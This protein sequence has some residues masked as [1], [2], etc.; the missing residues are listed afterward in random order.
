MGV[1][2]TRSME[3]IAAALG[4]LDEAAPL[5]ERADDIPNGGVLCALPALLHLGLLRHSEDRFDWPKGFYSMAS[6]FV[7]LAFLALGRIR[8]LEQLRYQAPGEWGKLLGLD[9]VPEVKTMREKIGML[10]DDA[11]RTAQW[12]SKLAA[13]WMAADVGAAGVLLIDGHTRVYHGKLAK[14]PRRYIA[15]EK[16]CLR[17]TSDYWVNAMNGDP[18]FCVTKAVDPG[19]I[20]TLEEDIVPRLLNEVP[21]Q[22]SAQQLEADA[23]LHRLTLIFDREGYSPEF[24]KRMKEKRI[25]ILTYKKNSGE[26]WASEEFEKKS[27]RMS[28]GETDTLLLAE[29][30]T[31]LSNGL[32]VREV[33]LLGENGHQTAVLSTDYKSDL[34]VIAASMFARWNQENFFKYMRQHYGLD[35]LIEYGIS[36]LPDTTRLVNPVWRG[37]D[38][39]LRSLIGKLVKKRAQFGAMT[40]DFE[41]EEAG[42]TKKPET[43]GAESNGKDRSELD[44]KAEAKAE[45]K[46][47]KVQAKSLEKYETQKGKL[48]EEIQTMGKE[49]SDL[50]AQRKGASKHVILKDLPLEQR[51]SQLLS[52]RKHFV[53]TIKLLAYRAETTLVGLIKETLGRDDEARS[54]VRAILKTSVNLR[55]N[56]AEG[57]LEIQ[58][59]GQAN[60]MHDECAAKLCRELNETETKYPGTNLRLQ[61]TTLRPAKSTAS[62][63]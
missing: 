52:A 3:R 14:L 9:R 2:T 22:P 60:P 57:I 5:F 46:A 10:G 53:H 12:S 19:L 63:S 40:I 56:P 7:L 47:S 28:N 37:L 42:Q 36:P 1:A 41:I 61:Y 54:F 17:A 25:A 58:L 43:A 44:E 62:V 33:R 20:K 8:S 6:I 38:G 32:W 34:S 29:R 4:G 48:L 15:R 30:G 16:L 50:T 21:G 26:L 13:D 35:A 18:F 39:Q 49:V 27:V 23:L 11:Q 31:Q 51:V 59:H 24:F 55:P 45:A